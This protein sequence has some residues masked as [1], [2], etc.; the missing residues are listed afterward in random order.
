M[1]AARLAVYLWWGM[2]VIL[3]AAPVVADPTKVWRWVVA[4]TI[5]FAIGLLY[6]IN[7]GDS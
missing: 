5:S 6:S 7:R 2:L 3:I 1:S 4:A